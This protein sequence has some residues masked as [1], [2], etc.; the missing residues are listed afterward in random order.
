[1]MPLECLALGG[2]R[3]VGGGF[4]IRGKCLLFLLFLLVLVGGLPGAER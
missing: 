3:L 2:G 1:M 4:R